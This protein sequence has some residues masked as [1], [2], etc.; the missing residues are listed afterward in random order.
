MAMVEDT[1]VLESNDKVAESRMAR[2][3][4]AMA[5]ESKVE[6]QRADRRDFLAPE[7]RTIKKCGGTGHSSHEVTDPY[8]ER[9]VSCSQK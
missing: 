9:L 7:G 4:D 3:E 8:L 1:M 5:L 2:V 6:H